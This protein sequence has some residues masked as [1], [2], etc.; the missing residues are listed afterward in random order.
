MDL[1]DVYH[2]EDHRLVPFVKPDSPSELLHRP[3]PVQLAS[4]LPPLALPPVYLTDIIALVL[5][6]LHVQFQLPLLAHQPV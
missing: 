5:L 2:A 1:T 4:P 3:L 6:V